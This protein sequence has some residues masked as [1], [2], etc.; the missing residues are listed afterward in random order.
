VSDPRV[1]AT[2]FTGSEAAGKK[3]FAAATAAGKVIWVE[4]GS[5]N[6]VVLLPGALAERGGEIAAELTMSV[7]SSAGQF[8]TKPGLVF[9]VG[10][11]AG[12]AFAAAVTEK[13]TA[14]GPQ[15][16]LSEPGCKRLCSGIEGLV[17]AG[18][19]LLAGQAAA[20]GPACGEGYGS[21]AASADAAQ[22]AAHR[23]RRQGRRAGERAGGWAGGGSAAPGGAACL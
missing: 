22:Q 8:C 18:V 21:S 2:G 5:I 7:T 9:F 14:I 10:D 4:M 20:S 19:K 6:P 16:L 1:G 3:L 12:N 15:V 13:F 23:P 11:A 17:R